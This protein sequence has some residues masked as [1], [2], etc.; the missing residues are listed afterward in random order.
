MAGT[1]DARWRTCSRH[2]KDI[3]ARMNP[4]L[5]HVHR[6]RAPRLPLTK[7]VRRTLRRV[8]SS[9][10]LHRL[11]DRPTSTTST[12]MT[13]LPGTKLSIKKIQLPVTTTATR[14]IL[15]GTRTTAG[16]SSS[17]ISPTDWWFTFVSSHLLRCS[18]SES[19]G[20]GSYSL[21]LSE[22]DEA[23][24]PP[25]PPVRDSSS[26]KGVCYGPGHEKYPSW[27]SAPEHHNPEEDVHAAAS[28]HG[29]SHR[30]KSWTDHTNYPK[31]K[32]AQYTRPHAKRPNPAF[33]QQVTLFFVSIWFYSSYSSATPEKKLGLRIIYPMGIIMGSWLPWN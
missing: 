15:R 31:E 4:R 9:N 13:S 18:Y 5:P 7:T 16:E 17:L 32:P 29:G 28:L 22:R 3:A 24:P 14:R 25:T 23:S 19:S 10:L 33:T 11:V 8:T 12:I 30:S 26:L 27:P 21:P 2:R 20:F 1:S 6:T